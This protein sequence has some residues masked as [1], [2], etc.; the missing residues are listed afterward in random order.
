M[1]LIITQYTISFVY[2]GYVSHDFMVKLFGNCKHTVNKPFGSRK[3]RC[4]LKGRFAIVFYLQL[5]LRLRNIWFDLNCNTHLIHKT[6]DKFHCLQAQFW[7]LKK[8]ITQ[9]KTH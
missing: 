6:I 3:L 9:F 1:Q 4:A 2:Q 8:S 5:E 7:D